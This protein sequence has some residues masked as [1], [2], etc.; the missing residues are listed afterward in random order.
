MGVTQRQ[1]QGMGAPSAGS[2]SCP[3]V[4]F[5]RVGH[6]G[7][8]LTEP[9]RCGDTGARQL[10]PELTGRG[11]TLTAEVKKEQKI[12]V[13]G[14][15]R[16]SVQHQCNFIFFGGGGCLKKTTDFASAECGGP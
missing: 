15:Q 3:S 1:S 10:Q 5:H 16:R 11:K 2:S 9:T 14:E 6:S 4:G 8:D 13:D 12:K 7:T